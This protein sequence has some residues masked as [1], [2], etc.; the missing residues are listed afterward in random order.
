ML[1]SVGCSK[2]YTLTI[3]ISAL[4]LSRSGASPLISSIL[5]TMLSSSILMYFATRATLWWLKL[6]LWSFSRT[7]CNISYFTKLLWHSSSI[8]FR[9]PSSTTFDPAIHMWQTRS[10]FEIELI[11]FSINQACC[12][13]FLTS[14]FSSSCRMGMIVPFMRISIE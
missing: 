5:Y 8:P 11:F 6:T 14:E 1:L 4:N 10:S 13:Y 7:F 3:I 12:T 2:C 9:N